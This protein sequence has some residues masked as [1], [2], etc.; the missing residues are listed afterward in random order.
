FSKNVPLNKEVIRQWL[1]NPKKDRVFVND[2]NIFIY[3]NENYGQYKVLMRHLG[4]Y[5]TMKLLF[6]FWH[7]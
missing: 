3:F 4:L 1:I 7:E 6:V 5:N 2:E